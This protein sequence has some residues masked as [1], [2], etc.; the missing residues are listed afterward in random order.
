MNEIT[1]TIK[2]ETQVAS[3]LI[4]KQF[5]E[6]NVCTITHVPGYGANETFAAINEVYGNIFPISFNEEVAYTI[7]HGSALVGQRA[8]CIMKTHGFEKA[9]NSIIHS[10]YSGTTAGFVTLLF[11]DVEGSHSDNILDIEALLK[12]SQVPYK[13]VFIER[14]AQDIAEAFEASETKQIPY[15][16]LIDCKEINKETE[17]TLVSIAASQNKYIRDPYKHVVC[18]FTAEHLYKVMHSK[19]N[20]CEWQKILPHK[21]SLAPDKLAP[22]QKAYVQK[23]KSFFESFKQIRGP[24]VCGDA[25]TPSIFAL[26]PYKCIDLVTYLGSS[27]PLA[28]GCYLAEKSNR[29]WA[30][31]GDFAF[32]SAGHMGLIEAIQ[33]NI[34]LKLAIFNNSKAGATGGQNIP[35]YLLETLLSG[36]KRFVKV[37]E[38][39]WEERI[40]KVAIEEANNS[41][42]MRI[43]V[44]NYND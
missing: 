8:A 19:L 41:E 14:I 25:S 37:I 16:L 39:P 27:V 33:R 35:P 13:K 36:Y 31:T 9:A 3:R 11:D 21:I 5:K 24:V 32:I 12:G 10:L 6:L 42:E 26:D 18:P 20:N 22:V 34:P 38:N 43:L 23:Y 7:A 2:K 44:L 1:Q 4:A 15:F 40:T 30:I 28:L 29:I 17:Q